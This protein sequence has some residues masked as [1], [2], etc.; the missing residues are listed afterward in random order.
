MY[1]VD[2]EKKK[3]IINVLPGQFIF[4]FPKF[5]MW[6]IKKEEKVLAYASVVKRLLSNPLINLIE[7]LKVRKHGFSRQYLLDGFSKKSFK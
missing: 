1:V 3:K 5:F 6:K 7:S 4:Y 2:Q